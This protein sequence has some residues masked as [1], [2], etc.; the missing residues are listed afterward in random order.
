MKQFIFAAAVLISVA[1]SNEE[2]PRSKNQVSE[3]AKEALIAKYPQAADVI[4]ANKNQYVIATFS[5]PITRASQRIQMDAWFDNGGAWY[6]TE[7]DITFDMLPAAVKNAFAAS[8]Y[9]KWRVDD[10]DLIERNGTEVVYVIEAE[11]NNQEVDLYY[12]PEGILIKELIDVDS[13]HDYEEYIPAHPATPIQTYLQTNYPQ[14][15]ILEIDKEG[16]YTEVEILDGRVKR[17]LLFNASNAWLRT[18]T[19]MQPSAVPTAVSQALAASEYADY[20][21]DDVDHYKTPDA[22]FY[23]YELK[24]SNGDLKIDIT[25]AGVVSV[26]ESDPSSDEEHT[27]TLSKTITDFIAQKYS[28]AKIKESEYNKG[29]LEVEIYHERRE[30]EVRFTAADKWVDTSWDVRRSELPKAVTDK[31]A[32]AY[33]SYEIDD[34][35]FIQT[36]TGDY[37]EIELEKNDQEITLHIR[38]DGS[39]Q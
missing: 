8:T 9:A 37:Y 4:W 20:R 1:C 31:L 11:N 25:P 6:M 12:S 2:N 15:R 14:A 7:S 3:T 17:E 18:K 21:I 13:D 22:E 34:I 24:S 35:E 27:G 32:S 26:V 38:A 10:V 30:K 19:E 39:I 33:A 5:A 29:Y 23:R 28:G 36:A 16:S